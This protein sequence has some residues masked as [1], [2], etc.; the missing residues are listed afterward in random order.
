MKIFNYSKQSIDKADIN[1]ITKILNSKYLTKGKVTINFEKKIKI[2]CKSNYACATINASASLIMACKSIG[3]SKNDYV[4]TSNI[5]YIASINCALHLGA[6]IKLIDIDQTN[7]ICIK[8]LKKNLI[9]AKKK[10]FCQKH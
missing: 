6:K 9:E 8:E 3:I 10:K 1:A 4:W 2:F 7:N 5:T